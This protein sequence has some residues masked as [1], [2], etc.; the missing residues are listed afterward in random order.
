MNKSVNDSEDE[1]HVCW[2]NTSRRWAFNFQVCPSSRGCREPPLRYNGGD[3]HEKHGLASTLHYLSVCW[4]QRCGK[5]PAFVA[6]NKRMDLLSLLA[7]GRP[8][9]ASFPLSTTRSLGGPMHM[10]PRL[11]TI[12]GITTT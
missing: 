11:P 7:G 10:H 8:Y 4:G 9:K 3:L 6:S 5:T 2:T 1:E 12:A